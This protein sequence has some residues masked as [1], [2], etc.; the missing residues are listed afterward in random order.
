VT[1]GRGSR[2]DRPGVAAER[3]VLAWDRTAL[4]LLGNGALL[5]VRDLRAAGAAA[6]VP[7][8]TTLLAA[9]AVAVLGRRRSRQL[10]GPTDALPSAAAALTTLG[11]VVALAEVAVLVAL[12]VGAAAP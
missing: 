12:L 3:T 4:A 6:L 1:A 8:A 9:L 2:A 7:V 10:R 5:L 11:V